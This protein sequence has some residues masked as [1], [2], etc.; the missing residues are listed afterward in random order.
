MHIYI[1]IFMCVCEL[2]TF[3]FSYAFFCLSL[4]SSIRSANNF[5]NTTRMCIYTNRHN[6]FSV[7]NECVAAATAATTEAVKHTYIQYGFHIFNYCS[8]IIYIDQISLNFIFNFSHT[9]AHTHTHFP[10]LSFSLSRFSYP[11]N[12]ACRVFMILIK[13]DGFAQLEVQSQREDREQ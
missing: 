7:K 9:H 1:Y 4:A 6:Y 2:A 10:S 12:L 5:L 8:D 11:L 3:S 13:N